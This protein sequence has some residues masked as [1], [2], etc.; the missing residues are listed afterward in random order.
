M[1]FQIILI[2][3]AILT[4][5][6]VSATTLHGT[7]YDLNLEVVKNALVEINTSPA[8][9]FIAKDGTYSFEVPQ[10]DFSMRVTYLQK[11]MNLT[12]TED[13]AVKEEGTYVF[14]IIIFP[15]TSEEEE[16]VEDVETPL[17]IGGNND[18]DKTNLIL[19]LGIVLLIGLI[20]AFLVRDYLRKKGHSKV[21][22][23]LENDSE[24]LV[25]D[26]LRKHE[27]RI[28]QRELRKEIPL[29]EAKISLLVSALEHKGKVDKIK[30]GRGN[31]IVK[32]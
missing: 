21:D 8:Q 5:S 1:R 13:L 4:C 30:K 16:L 28:T 9:R 20:S 10:G 6:I 17:D 29:S 11:G 26:I 31:I 27:G 7:I 15:D 18:G 19:W 25:L 22:E 2:L 12:F 23:E 3:L 14:D 32:K 24:Q